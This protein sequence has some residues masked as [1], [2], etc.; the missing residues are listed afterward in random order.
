[1]AN[2]IVT[3]NYSLNALT[4]TGNASLNLKLVNFID[5]DD[6]ELDHPPAD[7]TFSIGSTDA[8][9]LPSSSTRG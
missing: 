8:Y 3:P 7:D 2:K 6:N 9:C 1:M 5:F 4:D